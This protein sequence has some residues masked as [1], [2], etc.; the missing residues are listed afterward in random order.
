MNI[1]LSK[2]CKLPH[3]HFVSCEHLVLCVARPKSKVNIKSRLTYAKEQ[4][5]LGHITHDLRS[6]GHSRFK[7]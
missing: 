4:T 1:M 7:M 6:P 2:L 3:E 5:V